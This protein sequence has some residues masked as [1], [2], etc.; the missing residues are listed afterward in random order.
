MIL[1]NKLFNNNI[2]FASILLPKMDF[3]ANKSK[4]Y[5]EILDFCNKGGDLDI[6][7][8]MIPC[9]YYFYS[10]PVN[11]LVSAALISKQFD[12]VD[13]LVKNHSS[14]GNLNLPILNLACAHYTI[15]VVLYLLNKYP[16][17]DVNI[18][19]SRGYSCIIWTENP[20]IYKEL[21]C[22]GADIYSKY[23]SGDTFFECLSKEDQNEILEYIEDLNVVNIKPAKSK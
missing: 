19:C 20:V 12:I 1:L 15:E 11:Y 23:P 10:T 13:F 21:I 3:T 8:K 5:D 16:D 14:P 2:E 9:Q 6:L 17:I 4:I 22:R 7:S 18:K